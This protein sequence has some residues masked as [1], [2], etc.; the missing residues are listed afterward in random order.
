MA[1]NVTRFFLILVF[2]L[3]VFLNAA[4]VKNKGFRFDTPWLGVMLSDVSEK[5]LKNMGL[6]NGV[7]ISKVFKNSPADKAGLEIDDIIVTFDGEKVS[8]SKDMSSRV[9]MRKASDEVE[10]E[11]FRSGKMN[12]TTVKIEKR[13]S[14]KVF[15]Q[16][17]P[18]IFKKKIRHTQNSVFLGVKVESLTDQLRKYFNVS[19]GLG[20]LVSEVI[21]DS[22]AEKSGLKAGDVITKVE[23]R[24]VKNYKDLI[25]GLNYFDPDDKVEIYFV[26]D[27]SK[28]SVDVTLA[29]PQDKIEKMMWFDD[30]D[31]IHDFDVDL[32]ELEEIDENEIELKMDELDKSIKNRKEIRTK[33][34]V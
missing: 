19:E 1:R 26:R 21:E 3:P 17:E 16:K 24:E 8:D 10:L 15:M 5:T 7:R 30:N 28:K 31:F 4:Q 13:K 27:K 34:E 18:H 33:A 11:Y 32:N 23:D 29:K 9:K 14:P 25:R 2:T 12:S 22:P 6:D 20:V